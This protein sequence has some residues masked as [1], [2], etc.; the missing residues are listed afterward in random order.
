MCCILCCCCDSCNRYSSKCIELFIF[1]ISLLSLILTIFIFFYINSKHITLVCFIILIALII[2]S[3]LI[4]I[5]IG[6]IVIWRFKDM[7]TTKRI[8]LGEGFSIVG[9]VITIFYLIC[10]VSLVS[11]MYSHYEELNHPC[12]LIDKSEDYIKVSEEYGFIS[13][14]ITKDFCIENPDYSFNIVPIIEYIIPFVFAAILCILNFILIYFW[15]NDY[16]RIK[17][18]IRG[19]L[20][21][22]D[23]Q[24]IKNERNQNNENENSFDKGVNER[25]NKRQNKQLNNKYLYKIY[26]QQEN[27]IRYDIYG[28][29]I[30]KT[31]KENS[32]P[33]NT[34]D[35]LNT[36]I[37]QRYS[38]R[39]NILNNRVTIHGRNS[40]LKTGNNNI[41][42]HSGSSERNIINKLQF[43][44]NI[45]NNYNFSK[46]KTS[47]KAI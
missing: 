39:K 36:G 10:I 26:S 35:Y 16:R 21:D 37:T 11:L 41:I 14:I 40:I 6:L 9:L 8:K 2:F 28:R 17:F 4:L 30:I 22:F 31:S 42:G 46:S 15:F 27:G 44:K 5:S 38:K 29:P 19:S 3:F 20:N 32:N 24:E 33:T 12:L 18:L 13:D 45:T 47:D 34:K 1:T 43:T 7:I 23:A 25:I